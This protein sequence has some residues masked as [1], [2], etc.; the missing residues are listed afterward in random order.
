MNLRYTAR[1]QGRLG[2]ASQFLLSHPET[3]LRVALP[4]VVAGAVLGWLLATRPQGTS[5][6]AQS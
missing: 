3:L 1:L 6:A 2:S 4:Y 5:A